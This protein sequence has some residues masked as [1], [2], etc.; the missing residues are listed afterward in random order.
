MTTY[1]ERLQTYHEKMAKITTEYGSDWDEEYGCMFYWQS[2]GYGRPSMVNALSKD[3][4]EDRDDLELQRGFE[5][6]SFRPLPKRK[7]FIGTPSYK[8]I[9][10]YNYFTLKN[11][12][13]EDYLSYLGEVM[14]A[15]KENLS[16]IGGK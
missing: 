5:Y 7:G 13:M 11:R 2:V 12:E 3:Y 15:R 16:W 4:I 14:D 6:E 1:T 8:L 9:K 10:Y